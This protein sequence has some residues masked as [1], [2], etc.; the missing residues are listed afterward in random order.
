MARPAPATRGYYAA[1]VAVPTRW[2]DND[3]YGH[4]NNVA[5][6]GICDTALTLWQYEAG[7]LDPADATTPEGGRLV[8]AETGC[9]YHSEARFPDPLHAGL[10][11]GRMGNSS[12][13]LEIGLFAGTEAAACAEVF[14]V[15]VHVS[16][17][18]GRPLPLQDALR[19]RFAALGPPRD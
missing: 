9:V 2:Q 15:Q 19:G 5:Y 18:T 4:L 7:I 13:R 16:A 8:M 17:Q 1:F 12:L 6:L 11:L 14:F 3:A 10:R